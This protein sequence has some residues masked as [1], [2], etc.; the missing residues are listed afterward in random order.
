SLLVLCLFWSC[1]VLFPA[2]PAGIVLLG[3]HNVLRDSLPIGANSVLG[4][5]RRSAPRSSHEYPW[6]GRAFCQIR[7]LRILPAIQVW[8]RRGFPTTF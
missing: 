4:R 8:G 6:A 2:S 5:G 7:R 1:Y 3:G